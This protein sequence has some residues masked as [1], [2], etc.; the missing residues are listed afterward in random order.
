M[1]FHL[2]RA[3]VG[4]YI[5]KN[6]EISYC[7]LTLVIFENVINLHAGVSGKIIHILFPTI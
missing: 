2:E 3:G 1:R 5:F 7:Y 4:T 6:N